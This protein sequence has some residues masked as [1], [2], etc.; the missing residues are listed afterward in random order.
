MFG[1]M[2]VEIIEDHMNLSIWLVFYKE[3]NKMEKLESSYKI[4]VGSAKMGG[5]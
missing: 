1:F 4:V 3:I 5:G 2:G